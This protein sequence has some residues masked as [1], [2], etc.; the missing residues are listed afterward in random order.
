MA[1]VIPFPFYLHHV[2]FSLELDFNA[3]SRTV[4]AAQVINSRLYIVE[5][6]NAWWMAF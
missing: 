6:N 5:M 2:L 4:G 1:I 3:C